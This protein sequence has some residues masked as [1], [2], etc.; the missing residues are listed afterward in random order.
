MSATFV[1]TWRA[2]G[3]RVMRIGKY[4]AGHNA[5][6]LPLLL[7]ATPE[8]TARAITD[9]TALVVEGFPRSGNT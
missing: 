1:D 4:A 5:V 6:T 2:R 7:R 9:E 8:G 3:R